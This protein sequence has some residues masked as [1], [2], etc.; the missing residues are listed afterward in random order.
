VNEKLNLELSIAW[1][2]LR[3]LEMRS[4]NTSQD[5][6]NDSDNGEISELSLRNSPLKMKIKELETANVALKDSLRQ[7]SA[8]KAKEIQDL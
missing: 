3:E 5:I 1:K 4:F 2:S 7:L 6:L 8:S